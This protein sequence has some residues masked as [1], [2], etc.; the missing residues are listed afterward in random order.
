MAPF[1]GAASI[2]NTEGSLSFQ[3]VLGCPKSIKKGILELTIVSSRR[4]SLAVYVIDL[5]KV[6]ISLLTTFKSKTTHINLKVSFFI[7]V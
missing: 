4:I 5:D 2:A 7:T 6:S 1:G 3:S